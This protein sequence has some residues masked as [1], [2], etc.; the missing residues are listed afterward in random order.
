MSRAVLTFGRS[1]HALLFALLGLAPFGEAV[2]STGIYTGGIRC[3]RR[4]A[5]VPLCGERDERASPGLGP[6]GSQRHDGGTP[7]LAR[8]AHLSLQPLACNLY[9]ATSAA[10]GIY[11]VALKKLTTPA[12]RGFAFGVQYGSMGQSVPMLAAG[13]LSPGRPDAVMSTPGRENEPLPCGCSMAWLC[14]PPKVA[15]ERDRPF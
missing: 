1:R 15:G 2:L 6:C 14:C 3:P 10:P 5:M 8:R 12:T 13:P 7:L 4:A 9:P 11:T